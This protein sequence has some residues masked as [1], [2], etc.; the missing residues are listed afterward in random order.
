MKE[1][2]LLK[3]PDPGLLS[4]IGGA[5]QGGSAKPK[6]EREELDRE[7]GLEPEQAPPLGTD[8]ADPDRSTANNDQRAPQDRPA[9]RRPD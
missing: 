6:P 5:A 8:R 3:S 4:R 1:S 2:N 7:H 9:S